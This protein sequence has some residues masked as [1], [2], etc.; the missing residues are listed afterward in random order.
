MR[1]KTRHERYVE[2]QEG[3][4]QD[5][6]GRQIRYAFDCGTEI[7]IHNVYQALCQYKTAFSVTDQENFEKICA[8][9]IDT[10]RIMAKREGVLL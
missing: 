6:I 2:Y 9:F 4:L 7:A 3:N 10:I 5:Y 1:A 8:R